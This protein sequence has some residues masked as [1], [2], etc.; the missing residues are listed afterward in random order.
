M[1]GDI[2]YLRGV[3]AGRAEAA[4]E[5][6]ALRKDLENG[7]Q[8]FI[9]MRNRCASLERDISL[10]YDDYQD[11]VNQFHTAET[12]NA[13]LKLSLKIAEEALRVV[14]KAY[15]KECRLHEWN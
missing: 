9:S 11:A 8:A 3:A 2:V 13:R 15:L 4:A 7:E 12:E 6:N 5:V 10:E 14:I 1:I